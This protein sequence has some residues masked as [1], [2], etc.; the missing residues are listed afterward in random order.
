MA[1]ATRELE[2]FVRDALAGGA[3]KEEIAAALA[4]AAWP[5]EQV[6]SALDAW[7]DVPFQV[8]VPK[9]QP[10]LSAREAF[11]YLVLFASLYVAA[12]HLGSLIFD[13]INGFHRA[14]LT[15]NDE[16]CI[17][18]EVLLQT[19]HFENDIIVSPVSAFGF[20]LYLNFSHIFP[21]KSISLLLFV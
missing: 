11:L 10:Y 2:V 21:L 15:L 19:T 13:I 17:D 5:A 7:A 8:P 3:S 14:N 9:P 16:T 6:R 12:W 1:A 18:G 4:A 20:L